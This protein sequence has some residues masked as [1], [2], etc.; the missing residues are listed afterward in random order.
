MSGDTFRDGRYRHFPT[1]IL[2]EQPQLAYLLGMGPVR[3]PAQA[4]LD[5]YEYLAANDPAC[6]ELADIAARA[7]AGENI[8]PL[9]PLPEPALPETGLIEGTVAEDD[10]A[11]RNRQEAA[12]ESLRAS[13]ADTSWLTAVP[14]LR[15]PA[16]ATVTDLRAVSG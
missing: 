9:V 14:P 11:A 1:E 4:E 5:R 10:T 12:L 7:R 6:R 15:A 3:P 2:R 13:G 16:D 8:P